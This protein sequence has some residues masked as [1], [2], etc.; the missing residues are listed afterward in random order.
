MALQ[1]ILQIAAHSGMGRFFVP[2]IHDL[3]INATS[4]PIFIKFIK[5]D[6]LALLVRDQTSAE[7]VLREFEVSYG[8]ISS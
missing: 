7:I 2:H 8:V 1:A 5:V 4:D 6:V 3:F